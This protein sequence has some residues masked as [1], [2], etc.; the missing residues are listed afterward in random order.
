MF[1]TSASA[2]APSPAIAASVP[3]AHGTTPTLGLPSWYGSKIGREERSIFSKTGDVE[4]FAG[5]TFP[6][7]YPTFGGAIDRA[8]SASA[9][10][11]G[12][13]AILNHGGRFFLTRSYNAE[14]TKQGLY[15]GQT[16]LGKPNKGFSNLHPELVALVDGDRIFRP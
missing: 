1:A 11:A 12:A 8:Q 2:A 14:P 13:V 5:H 3:P 4:L 9:D 10:A 16:D 15:G 7:S 6:I